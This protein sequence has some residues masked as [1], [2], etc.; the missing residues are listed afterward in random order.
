VHLYTLERI[1]MLRR[2]QNIYFKL[3][4]KLFSFPGYISPEAVIFGYRLFLDREPESPLE[5][6]DGGSLEALLLV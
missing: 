2:M 4:G 6:V 5:M 1:K 3:Y